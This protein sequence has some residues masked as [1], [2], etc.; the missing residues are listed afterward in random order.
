MNTQRLLTISQK[1]HGEVEETLSMVQQLE[2]GVRD[3]INSPNESTQ[4]VVE[5]IYTDLLSHLESAS[6]NK[7]S[8]RVSLA[9]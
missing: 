5:K 2:N 4:R 6:S 3:A 8:P 9:A 7:F 1:L